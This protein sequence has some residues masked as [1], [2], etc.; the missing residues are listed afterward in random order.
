MAP[1]GKKRQSEEEAPDEDRR[2]P[3]RKRSR[4]TGED[5]E[6]D[7]GDEGIATETPTKARRGRPPGSTKIQK[8]QPNGNS[9]AISF[10]GLSISKSKPSTPNKVRDEVDKETPV[11]FVRNADRSAR[12]KSARNLLG[13]IAVDN[14]SEGSDAEDEDLLAR[15]IW[16]ADEEAATS[17]QADDSEEDE[18]QAESAT[19]A[20]IPSKRKPGRRKKKSSTPPTNLPPHEQYF[21][22]NRPGRAKTSSNTLSSLSLLSH[23]Q[24]H[25]QISAYVD[26][27]TSSHEYLHSLHARSFPQWRFELSQSFNICLYGYGSKR[28]LVTDF[29][30]YLHRH[31]SIT[32]KILIVNGYTPNLTLRTLLTNLASL[33]YSC[34]ASSLPKLPTQPRDLLSALLTHL[35]ADP[36]DVNASIYIFINSLDAAPLRRSNTPALLAQLAAH[37]R[38]SLLATCDTPNFPLL[39]DIPTRDRYNFLF[40]DSTTF[41][42]YASTESASAEVPDVV[43]TVNALLGRSGRTIKGKEGVGFVLRSLPENARSLYRILISEILAGID[44]ALDNHDEL[45]GGGGDGY[46]DDKGASSKG[47][48]EY[49]TLY[50]K[51]VE[52]FICSSEMGF[53][54]LLKEFWDHDMIVS[55]RESGAGGAVLGVP[56]RREEMEAILEELVG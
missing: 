55:N 45:D 8:S 22:Q 29:A 51:T 34:A 52:E 33:V 37:P 11:L 25:D 47:G 23:G 7:I 18:A 16:E 46:D 44:S 26:P 6:S 50:Q 9:S 53:Q 24:Y 15:K 36:Q 10:K 27:H 49:N 35:S 41:L 40:H 1:R 31:F 28:T 48:I 56:W 43:D 38:I 12:R 32:P 14:A 42:S 13:R 3:V 30:H 54:Q 17:D 21:W 19:A 4:K 39:W 20:E 5:G 2:M